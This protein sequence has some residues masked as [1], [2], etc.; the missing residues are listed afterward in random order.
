[1][2]LF[3]SSDLEL[4]QMLEGVNIALMTPLDALNFLNELKQKACS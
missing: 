4:K 3:S 1:M 2:D